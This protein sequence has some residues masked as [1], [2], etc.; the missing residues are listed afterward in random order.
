MKLSH[1][2]LSVVFASAAATSIASTWI[3]GMGNI[4]DAAPLLPGQNTIGDTGSLTAIQGKFRFDDVDVY[5]IRITDPANFRATTVGLAGFLDTQLFLFNET[6]KGVTHNDDDPGTNSI[7]STI[8]GQFVT[9][10]G[11]YYLAITQYN[12]DPQ[13]PAFRFLWNNTPFDVERAPDGPGANELLGLWTAEPLLDGD[14]E[15]SLQGCD[16]AEV[17]TTPPP[18]L[19]NIWV[20]SVDA[21]PLPPGQLTAG[22]GHCIRI[23]G[24]LTSDIDVDMFAIRIDDPTQFHASTIG[25]V[26]FDT[27]LFL[28]NESGMGITFND[29]D[30]AI[31]GSWSQITGQFVPGPGIYYLAI[32]RRDRDPV[33]GKDEIWLDEPSAVERQPDGPGFDLPIVG[34]HQMQGGRVGPY[35][36]ILSGAK[37]AA[38][39]FTLAPANR[40][41]LV[42]GT[43][44][45]GGLAS[46]SLS[47]NVYMVLRAGITFSAS[48][49]PIVAEFWGTLPTN[50]PADLELMVES[51]G[52][53][54]SL[55][56][57]VEV[58]DY[59]VGTWTV[60][61]TSQTP[62][63]TNPDLVVI[64]NI[65]AQPN[66]IGAEN[67]VRMRIRV[68]PT[69]PVLALPW[70]Y[71]I[72]QVAWRVRSQ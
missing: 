30:P 68:K 66:V 23:D 40:F 3:E 25:Q 43:L 16:F 26:D 61:N 58:Y 39:G 48:Q 37:F 36:I 24:T 50:N 7:H 59:V 46:V 45:S 72:D 20:E 49:D 57:I 67:E 44:M 5:K 31:S 63:G 42:R 69:S 34:W 4:G 71:S 15:I 12:R 53:S 19:E 32:S 2:C 33:S 9:Q 41:D 47:D 65:L 35:S 13:S 62:T 14:Y 18:P 55:R 29:D 54:S 6:G 38:E 51:R 22:E 10:P 60:I 8:T 21:A 28:F 56:Q 52:T 1:I 64:A 27:Q 11:I 70:S 17:G